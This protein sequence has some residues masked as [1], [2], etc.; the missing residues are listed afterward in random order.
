MT[1]SW[2][3]V[4]TDHASWRFIRDL[5]LE[6]VVVGLSGQLPCVRGLLRL[7]PTLPISTPGTGAA[8]GGPHASHRT[9]QAAGGAFGRNQREETAS[10]GCA[11]TGSQMGTVLC[12]TDSV[13]G[14]G[15]PLP[16]PEPRGPWDDGDGAGSHRGAQIAPPH[17]GC[18]SPAAPLP[19][20]PLAAAGPPRGSAAPP[21]GRAGWAG[22]CLC[23]RLAGTGAPPCLRCPGARGS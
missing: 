22:R 3:H 21:R 1:A 14:Y 11:G 23:G 5:D 19:R 10:W 17:Q 6:T 4:G 8:G 20:C 13:S 16:G 18:P 7:P 9:G 12:G 15:N 2:G